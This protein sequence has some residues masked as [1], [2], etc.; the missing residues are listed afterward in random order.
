MSWTK[1][2]NIIILILLLFNLFLLLLILGQQLRSDRYEADTLTQTLEALARHGITVEE[3]GLPEQTDTPPLSVVCSSAD[4]AEA[5]RSLLNDGSPVLSADGALTVYRSPSGSVS[6]RSSGEFSA[7]LPLPQTES[8]AETL[9]TG[10]LDQLGLSAWS[11][12]TSVS[13]V[14]GIRSVSVSAIPLLNGVPVFNASITLTQT[15]GAPLTLA[16][17]LPGP[18]VPTTRQETPI[19]LPTALVSVLEYVLDRGIVCRS[20]AR[21]TPGYTASSLADSLRLTPCWLV[22][23]DTANYYVDALTGAVTP[24]V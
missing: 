4:Q 20:I 1:L 9:L 8:S 24:L 21:I 15:D 16:G 12:T 19:T 17:W 23:T 5:A 10:F 14:N 2:K 22:E 7:S 6:F 13:P 11:H 3:S 18:A